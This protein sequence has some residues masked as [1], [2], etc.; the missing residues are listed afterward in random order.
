VSKTE[1]DLITERFKHCNPETPYFLPGTWLGPISLSLRGRIADVIWSGMT[2]FFSQRLV[3]ALQRAGVDLC[4]ARV[5]V[6]HEGRRT[7]D[8][9][10]CLPALATLWSTSALEDLFDR[11]PLCGGLIK[12]KGVSAVQINKHRVYDRKAWPGKSGVVYSLEHEDYLFSDEFVKVAA[13]SPFEGL[14]FER[15][16]SW[17]RSKKA[18]SR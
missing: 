15:V 2:P 14:A 3:H 1:F 16:G 11:C 4:P 10:S 8:Y 5:S 17:E 9:Y 6:V 7:V 12:K 13:S 18:H